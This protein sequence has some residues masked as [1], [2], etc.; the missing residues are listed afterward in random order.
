[1]IDKISLVLLELVRF[2]SEM[3]VSE[4]LLFVDKSSCLLRVAEMVGLVLIPTIVAIEI[5]T[6]SS[7]IKSL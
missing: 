3:V 1:M 4:C 7:L 5:D 6:S 2:V